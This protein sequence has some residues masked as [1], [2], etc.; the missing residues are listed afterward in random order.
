VIFWLQRKGLPVDDDTVERIFQKA[1]QSNC[2]LREDEIM[3]CLKST[4]RNTMASA[5]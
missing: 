1:K 5:D 3:Q 4:S 2:T